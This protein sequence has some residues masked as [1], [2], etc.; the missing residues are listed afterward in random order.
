MIFA[1]LILGIALQAKAADKTSVQ[2]YQGQFSVSELGQT[3]R[4]PLTE[5]AP[6]LPKVAAFRRNDIFAVWD[7]RG[8]TI[9]NGEKAVSYRLPDI[10]LSPKVF[11]REEITRTVRRIRNGECLKTAAALSGAKRIGKDAFFLLRWEDAKSEPWAEVLVRVDLSEENPQTHLVGRFGG[12]SMARHAV[13]DKLQLLHGKLA[14]IERSG[15]TWGLSTFDPS[16]KEFQTQPIGGQLS[17]LSLL[18]TTQA[19]FTETSAYG[20]NIAGRVDLETGT[21]KVLYEG[22]EH[23]QFVDTAAPELI[24]AD[25]GTKTKVVNAKTGSIR[26]FPSNLHAKRS[27][28]RVIL[29]TGAD[30]PTAV[31]LEDP[32]E[33]TTLATWRAA[34]ANK[35]MNR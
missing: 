17:W 34:T 24:L 15:A 4:F 14:V 27:D 5:D 11:S 13:D 20:T 33:W 22:R 30:E 1:T 28:Q 31:W 19:L 3:T 10:A 8:L 2:Y 26:I 25:S 32:V 35:A 6:S 9:R 18:N 21:R 7:E 23:L 12:L 16:T 29:W